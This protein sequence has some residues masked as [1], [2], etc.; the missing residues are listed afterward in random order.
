[1]TYTP[2][3]CRAG[4]TIHFTGA[5][6]KHGVAWHIISV[7]HVSITPRRL[8]CFGVTPNHARRTIERCHRCRPRRTK[9]HASP[10]T[11]D[12]SMKTR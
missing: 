9:P 1:M 12:L 3:T 2:G 8:L 10:T 7:N 11:C 6:S 5:E 4:Q